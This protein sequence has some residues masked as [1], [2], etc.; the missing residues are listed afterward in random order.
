MKFAAPNISMSFTLEAFTDEGSK[1]SIQMTCASAVGAII[2]ESSVKPLMRQRLVHV[3][4]KHIAP[5][6]DRGRLNRLEGESTTVPSIG[7]LMIGCYIL[8]ATDVNK[9]N[10]TTTRKLAVIVVEG[11]SS[12]TFHLSS[13]VAVKFRVQLYRARTFVLTV[14]LKLVAVAPTSIKG[15]VPHLVPGLLRAFAVSDCQSEVGCKLVAL[16]ALERL[17][18]LEGEK[19]D[20]L[21]VKPAIVSLLASAMNQKNGLLRRAAIDVRNTWYLVT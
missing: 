3:C 6:V 9:L 7:M 21:T 16:Q 5:V 13:P 10:P 2:M 18:F 8:S 20:I 14:I 12:E 1:T 19:S 4:L 11:L 17:A 15:F